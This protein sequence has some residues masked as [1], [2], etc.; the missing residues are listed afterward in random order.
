MDE[1]CRLC[2]R[3][4]R[5][6]QAGKHGHQLDLEGSNRHGQQLFFG[7]C[8][9]R[10]RLSVPLRDRQEHRRLR[11]RTPD[12]RWPLVPAVHQQLLLFTPDRDWEVC[13]PGRLPDAV[14][15]EL[16]AA[17]TALSRE[18]AQR[19]GWSKQVQATVRAA[20]RAVVAMQDTPGAA[21]K[22]SDV[23]ALAS[24]NGVTVKHA[25]AV[26]AEAG[27]L[28]DDLPRNGTETWFADKT[29]ELPE[30]VR[31]ELRTWLETI[32]NGRT[33]PPRFK[34]LRSHSA[35][36]NYA[37]AIVPLAQIWAT[38]HEFLREV[39]QQ[40][41][42]DALPAEGAQHAAAITAVRSL[43]RAL[44]AH[45]LVFQN[46]TRKLGSVIVRRVP[47][48]LAPDLVEERLRDPDPVRAVL[49]ALI[50]FHALSV[51][52]LREVLTTDIHDG[53]LHQDHRVIL[54][55]A[56]VRER[57]A[58]YLDYRAQRWPRTAKPHLFINHQTAY[59]TE[60]T[61]N[62]WATGVLGISARAIREDRI[63]DE[64]LATGGDVR[65]VWDLFGMT[66]SGSQRYL[67]AAEQ[68][69]LNEAR[70]DTPP[71]QA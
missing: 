58:D 12:Y 16:V 41:I 17:L 20:L 25:T 55:A 8:D 36:R 46:P 33:T 7:D 64:A 35:I 45:Q 62:V 63:L 65:R 52:D 26:L 71:A 11:T 9:R 53:R 56:P 37:R 57:L 19:L 39:T 38:S 42:L 49:G 54:L 23:Q 22:A 48:Q 50:A 18:R 28:D 32:Q 1:V 69:R 44:K 15:T 66:P 34:P 14:D 2:R 6:V 13:K 29:A 27:F 60:P 30:H 3:Q 67:A 31:D 5:L 21:I 40:E 61:S 47:Q 24:M 59:D 51:Q 4:A 43:F 68:Q 70:T 10:V